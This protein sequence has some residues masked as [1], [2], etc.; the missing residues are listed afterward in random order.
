M[1][2]NLALLLAI[3]IVL[4]LS[5]LAGRVWIDPLGG[6]RPVANPNPK[7]EAVGQVASATGVTADPLDR[8]TQPQALAVPVLTSR[9]GPIAAI[10]PDGMPLE[11]R[12]ERITSRAAIQ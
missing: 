10:D 9:D 7:P 4:P 12:S 8:L 2:L 3:A 5:L 1:R 11:R 6:V